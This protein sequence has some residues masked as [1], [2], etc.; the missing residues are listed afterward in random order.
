METYILY[1]KTIQLKKNRWAALNI[2]VLFNASK[3]EFILEIPTEIFK[4]NLI[5]EFDIKSIGTESN[6]NHTSFSVNMEKIL[7]HVFIKDF[8][9]VV[10]PDHLLLACKSNQDIQLLLSIKKH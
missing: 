3:D 9:N 10:S 7:Q 2:P 6:Q 5:F 1:Q 4:D 8:E